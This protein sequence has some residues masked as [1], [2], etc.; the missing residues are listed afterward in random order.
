MRKHNDKGSPERLP[1]TIL[2]EIMNNQN[3]WS[4]LLTA[5]VSQPGLIL[6]AYS[7]FHGYSLSNQ[8]A[9]LLQ[10]HMRALQ[11]GPMHTYQGWQKIGR[12]VRKGEK[13]IWLCMPLTRKL[14]NA[15]D[16][17]KEVITSFVWKPNW[18][19]LSQT[20]GEPAPMPE[21]P[22]WDKARALAALNITETP[23]QHTDGNTMGYARK[24]EIAISP[25]CPLPH[26]TL[27]HEVAH[28][29]LGHTSESDFNDSE[30]TPRNLRE[31]EAEA[32]AM[33]LCESLELPGF[34]YCRGYIQGWLDGDVIPEKSAQKIFGAADRIL[35]AGRGEKLKEGAQD[36]GPNS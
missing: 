13:A 31:V 16:D 5:A 34:D 8:I 12:Q 36:A 4:D 27:L 9:A 17:D 24:R 25:L 20:E 6:K 18:F 33:L 21:I 29:E 30:I 11:P 15:D 22:E 3:K 14:K 7:N 35:K 32:V 2:E 1:S 26:K 19:T 28:I 10:C 23:F